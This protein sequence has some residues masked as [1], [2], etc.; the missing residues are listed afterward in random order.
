MANLTPEQLRDKK[1]YMINPDPG[2][3][4][5]RNRAIINGTI[6]K[7]NLKRKKKIDHYVDTVR[8]RSEAVTSYLFSSK[9]AQG[10]HTVDKYFGKQVLAYLRGQKIVEE[11]AYLE[12]QQI[13]R[14]KEIN[15]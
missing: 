14:L 3:S 10:G 5:E 11:M 13:K 8:E 6:E 4:P 9:G 1:F 15:Q 7:N 2:F 12:E